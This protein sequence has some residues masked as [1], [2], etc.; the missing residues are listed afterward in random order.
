M[1]DV[2][3]LATDD[4][5]FERR[6]K[7]DDDLDK[8]N[9]PKEDLR[10]LSLT[11]FIKPNAFIVSIQR[12]I[13]MFDSDNRRKTFCSLVIWTCFLSSYFLGLYNA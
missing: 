10:N 9:A 8:K 1:I 11:L 4:I 12:L 2:E 3:D 7:D 5:P 13:E 6:S